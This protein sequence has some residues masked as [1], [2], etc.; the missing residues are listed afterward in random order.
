MRTATLIFKS[1]SQSVISFAQFS[2][3]M[4]L[5]FIDVSLSSVDAVHMHS[6][7]LFDQMSIFLW[8][9]LMLL[10]VRGICNFWSST[11]R[12]EFFPIPAQ[13]F[14]PSSA[15]TRRDRVGVCVGGWRG[16]KSRDGWGWVSREKGDGES[17]HLGGCG[18]FIYQ[19]VRVRVGAEEAIS[20]RVYFFLPPP[21]CTGNYPCLFRYWRVRGYGFWGGYCTVHTYIW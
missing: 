12:Q 18:R 11:R 3:L 4:L 20:E 16:V 15:E 19:G 10:N 2:A 21:R 17:G 6:R 13:L 14:Q 7:D 5:S 9:R 8:P 1:F